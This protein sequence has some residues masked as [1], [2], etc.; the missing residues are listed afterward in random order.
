MLKKKYTISLLLF[1]SICCYGNFP[2]L[3]ENDIVVLKPNPAKD[4]FRVE[5]HDDQDAN[6]VNVYIF[7]IIANPVTNYTSK[8]ISSSIIE[9]N[10]ESL[11]S[12]MYI[13]QIQGAN[14]TTI[15]KR[16]IVDKN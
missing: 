11:N 13:V 5:L 3:A 7:D 10:I 15:R 8:I 14:A 12:G 16:L 9:V 2:R 4:F 6:N 1:L